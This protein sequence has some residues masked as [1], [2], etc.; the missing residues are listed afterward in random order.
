V[1]IQLDANGNI[2]DVATYDESGANDKPRAIFVNG[3]SVYV[4]GAG[5]GVGTMNDV[6]T[7][8]YDLI[9]GIE[10]ISEVLLLS[11]Y[12]NPFSDAIYISLPR[13]ANNDRLVITNT[14]GQVCKN[15][16]LE[17]ETEVRINSK[18]MPA[19]VYSVSLL[20]NEGIVIAKT[21]IIAQ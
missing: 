11:A 20:N 2:L 6:I 5:D 3:T 13:S 16:A 17:N 21:K 4:T 15:I 18:G 1:T 7:L 12:P 14:L 10:P 8:R 19:G 9:S